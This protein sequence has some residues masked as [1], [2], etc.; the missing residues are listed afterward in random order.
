[1]HDDILFNFHI[2]KPALALLVR[3]VEKYVE[4][5]PGGHPDEQEY[6]KQILT[7]LR[8][9]SLELKFLEGPD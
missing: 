9:A 4:Q 5:W 3:A 8:K 6:A 7:E 1:M 2:D